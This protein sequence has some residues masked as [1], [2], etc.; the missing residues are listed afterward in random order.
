VK[1]GT[2]G[3]R[4]ESTRDAETRERLLDVGTRLF[5][6][7]GYHH[8]TVRDICREAHANVAAVNYYFDGKLGLYTEIVRGAIA[9]VRES[10]PTV[11]A[12]AGSSAEER[13]RHYVRTY[14]PRLAKPQGPAV[15][16]QKLMSHETHEPTPLAPW[17]AEQVILPR[18]RY[19]SDA[20]AELL[21]C[22]IDDPRVVRCVMSLQAQCLFY[23]PS[24]F[25]SAA[26]HEWEAM[27][28]A[29]VDAIAEHIAAFTL[30]G[31]AHLA[32]HAS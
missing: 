9:T 3:R 29:D 25:R 12:S 26:F 5:S 1:T 30:A 20:I 19:L 31:I 23:L 8:V 24:R 11:A 10:D 6:E 7:Q 18:V 4:G 28:D 22:P 32:G 14:V 17:I 21:G 2:G 15:W 16:M 13:I 27:V